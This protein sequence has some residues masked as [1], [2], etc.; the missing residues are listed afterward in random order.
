MPSDPLLQPYRLAPAAVKGK[1]VVVGAGPGGLE[2]A[3]VAA[4]RGHTVV[5]FEASSEPGG[6]VRLTAQSPR[7]R[8]MLGVIIDSRMAQCSARGVTFRFDTLAQAEDVLAEGPDVVIIAT[9]GRPQTVVLQSGNERVISAW[10][11]IS[12]GVRPAPNVLLFDDA[13]GHAGLQA[14]ELIAA[15]GAW[16]EIM[17]PDRSFA[18]EITPIT[19]APY[20]RSLHRPNVTF[21]VTYRLEKVQH[22]GNSLQANTLRAI[23]GSVYGGPKQERLVD[24]VVVNHGM[25]P[26][27]D[28]YFALKPLSRNGGTADHGAL[29]AGRPQTTVVNDQST[30]QL[31]RIGDAVAA[32]N[33]HAAIYDA[34]QLV[35][36]L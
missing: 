9:G 29:L 14:A 31:F 23:I 5:V 13:G 30:F 15:T 26:L 16:L 24:Q 12:G 20:L 22:L 1:I 28:L 18:R 21:T 2:A 7:H 25:I 3:R 10:D 34:L 36:D 19:L 17:T 11:I 27:N 35:K 32:R 4:E 6:Q 8:E 33:T